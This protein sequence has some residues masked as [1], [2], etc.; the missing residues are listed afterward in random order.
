VRRSRP[1]VRRP[2]GVRPDG[3]PDL[4]RSRGVRSGCPVLCRS[5]GDEL[6][7]SRAVLLQ[8][9]RQDEEV[10]VPRHV[11][12]G[13]EQVQEQQEE[14]WLRLRFDLRWLQCRP[15]LCRAGRPDLRR[16][17]RELLPLIDA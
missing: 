8:S 16:S 1:V 4:R 6:L 15:E 17:G 9:L 11:R 5:R 2:R 13:Q 3:R 14:P 10:L 7:R 12:Q